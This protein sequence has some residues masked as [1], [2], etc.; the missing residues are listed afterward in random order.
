M[1]RKL[2]A[3][4]AM[5]LAFQAVSDAASAFSRRTDAAA[6]ADLRRLLRLM[7]KDKNGTVSKSEFTNYLS[8]R[9]DKLDVDHDRRLVPDEL[10]AFI[11]PNC[12]ITT[13]P[14]CLITSKPNKGQR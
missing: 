13:K 9:F 12:R 11:I 5:S 2:V 7:D 3:A 10:R 1:V 6:D 4:V 14:N 8:E